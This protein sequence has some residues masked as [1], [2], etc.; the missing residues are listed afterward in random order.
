[1]R[2]SPR[3][4]RAQRT[5]SYIL[6]AAAY[7]L[8]ERG[9]EGFTTNR[10]AER[11]GV[12]IASLYQYFPDKAAILAALQARHAARPDQPDAAPARERL[13]ELPL[14]EMLRALVKG[15]LAEH[16]ANP[17]MHRTLLTA[18]PRSLRDV[19]S[20]DRPAQLADMLGAKARSADEAG[21]S[22]FIARHALLGVID[23]AV[24]TRPEWL[25][26]PVFAGELTRLLTAYLDPGRPTPACHRRQGAAEARSKRPMG[27]GDA[28]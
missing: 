5:V 9:L 14:A 4:A 21:M 25:A 20:P 26:N 6:D 22:L 12:N 16:A 28:K 7:I 18:L 24:C 1:M 23:E 27:Q 17:A 2:K 15:A 13:A 3:Q 10:I 8:A 19:Q 11:A